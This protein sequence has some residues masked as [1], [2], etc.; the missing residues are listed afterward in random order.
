MAAAFST[1]MIRLDNL[2]LQTVAKVTRWA[3]LGDPLPPSHDAMADR[4]TFIR[5]AN[6]VIVQ[7][8]YLRAARRD[9][10][11]ARAYNSLR[12]RGIKYQS[13]FPRS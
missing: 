2:T 12:A 8:R 11:N 3:Q 10:P 13:T 7:L 4:E 9:T 5:R 1:E 6:S